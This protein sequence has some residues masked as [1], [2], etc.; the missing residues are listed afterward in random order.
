MAQHKKSRGRPTTRIDTAVLAHLRQKAGLTQLGLA[1]EV[2]RLAKK[3]SS[4]Q[5]S[6][7][8]TG[9]R[10][11]KKGT[12]DAGLAQHL[13]TVLKTP[14]EILRGEHPF[15]T[16]EPAP[17]YVNELEALLRKRVQEETIPELENALQYFRENGYDDPVR[18]LAEEL[19]R[20]LEIAPLSA[21]KERWATLSAITGMTRRQ[22]LRPVGHEGLWLLISSGPPGPI[23]HELLGGIHGVMQVLRAEWEDVRQ[24]N[25]FCDS[26]IT[27]SDEKPWFKVSWMHM[28]IPEWVREMRFVRC[29]PTE[30]GLIWVAPTD[31][32][33]FW[34]DQMSN[35]A[36]EYFDYVK[37][38]DGIESP[39][40]IANLCLLIKKYLS[41]NEVEAQ[42]ASSEETLLEVH[43]GAVSEMPASTL[44]SF[45]KD[46]R[47]KFIVVNWLC[48]GLWE[49]LLPHLSEWPLKY[50][51]VDAAP[52]RIDVRVRADQIPIRE[53]KTFACP[54]PFGTRLS[55][56]LA[57][58][59]DSGRHKS[60]P[61]S[62]TSVEDVC[63]KLNRSFQEA[64]ATSQAPTG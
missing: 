38:S 62:R 13:A 47:A 19:N 27:F 5:A 48:S 2:Y 56:S 40:V 26:V 54:P 57:E 34:L 51:S 60:V 53:W 55:I 63:A 35:G 11:E 28:R 32:D 18:G 39:S 45:S 12:L 64:L 23:R 33:G 61:W 58:L 9:Q 30:T 49:A 44:A 22:M 21:S 20:E 14:V 50:W 24:S 43:H 8:N 4:S 17:S 31:N 42:Q 1:E 46:G 41:P 52:G 16:P 59:T 29:Q 36:Y 6:L 37:T 7:K 3:R 15:P 25:S 10:W